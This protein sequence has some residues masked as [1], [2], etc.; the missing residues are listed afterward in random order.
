M[1]FAYFFLVDCMLVENPENFE[2]NAFSVE[3]FEATEWDI[4][5]NPCALEIWGLGLSNAQ[6]LVT[7]R[8]TPVPLMFDAWSLWPFNFMRENAVNSGEILG[9]LKI[10]TF[11]NE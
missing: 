1:D 4:D 8:Y 6:E 7:A 3:H 10:S 9:N 2:N 5:M 11:S